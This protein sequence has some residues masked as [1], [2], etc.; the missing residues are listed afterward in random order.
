MTPGQ[1]LP[2]LP[3]SS[4]I[5]GDFA[6]QLVIGVLVH[7][8][9]YVN[10]CTVSSLHYTHLRLKYPSQFSGENFGTPNEPFHCQTEANVNTISLPFWSILG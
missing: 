5:D 10:C 7:F 9:I 6:L 8:F 1:P 2:Q 3:P 4:T